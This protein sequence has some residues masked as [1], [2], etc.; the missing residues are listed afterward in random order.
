[1]PQLKTFNYDKIREGDLSEVKQ[2]I[3]DSINGKIDGNNLLYAIDALCA[4]PNAMKAFT[5]GFSKEWGPKSKVGFTTLDQGLIEKQ[6]KEFDIT[7]P[8]IATTIATTILPSLER[9][10]RSTE[11]LSRINTVQVSS[12]SFVQMYDMDAEQDGAI[13]SEVAAGSD[14]DEVLR[15]GDRLIPNQKVQ[16]SMKMSEFVLTSLDANTLGKYIA[17]LARRVQTR[18]CQAILQNGSVATNGTARGDNLRGILNNYGV[19]GT[20]DATGT[21]GAISYAT[22]AATDAA[23]VAAG[24][25]ASTDAYDLVVKAKAFLLPGNLIDADED[26]YSLISNRPSWAQIRT[27]PDLNGRYKSLSAIDPATGRPVKQV[28]DAEFLV[29]PTSQCPNGRVYIVPLKLYTLAVKGDLMNLNDGGVVQLKE[30][31]IQFVSRT[32]VS[33]SMEYGQKFRP[34]TA[35]TVDTTVP[36]NAEQNAFRVINLV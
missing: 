24:G 10:I 17:R 19:N 5:E 11:I 12:N 21:I 28:D 29:V 35:V 22:K 18:L 8:S 33:G 13:L 15:T 36:D 26:E 34:T 4:N 6:I 14:V 9:L 31:L 32:W 1:M 23:I 2:T 25:V 7:Q 27:V 16:A 3:S 30:G 20:G